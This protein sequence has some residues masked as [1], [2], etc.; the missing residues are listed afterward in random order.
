[1]CTCY[2]TKLQPDFDSW[3]Y[4]FKKLSDLV[5]ARGDIFVTEEHAVPGQSQ[6]QLYLKPR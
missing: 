4:D 2:L 3:V 1:M 5:K 6:K